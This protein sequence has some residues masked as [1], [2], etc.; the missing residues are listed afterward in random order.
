MASEDRSREATQDRR[1]LVVAHVV[2]PAECPSNT[3]ATPA[4]RH[5]FTGQT[6]LRGVRNKTSGR[7]SGI[8]ST[9]NSH[10]G[11]AAG[12]APSFRQAAR[13]FCK[14]LATCHR[15]LAPRLA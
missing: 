3:F 5:A 6:H 10:L 13:N 8:R 7:R 1:G 14:S 11:T 9:T 15:L 2:A 12:S 4:S